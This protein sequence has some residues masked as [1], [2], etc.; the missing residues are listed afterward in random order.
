MSAVSAGVTGAKGSF[1]KQAYFTNTITTLL[2]AMVAN[3]K[4]VEAR[5]QQ[6]L[7]QPVADYPLPA[8]LSDLEAY[9]EAGTITG[10]LTGIAA[11]SGV[12]A[13]K[14]DEILSVIFGEDVA[15]VKLEKF[16]GWDGTNFTDAGNKS[17]LDSWMRLQ[18]LNP[19]IIV[20][21]LSSKEF[22]DRRAEAVKFFKL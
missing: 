19:N 10:A 2:G 4:T 12:K 15:T 16:I 13:N 22:A 3:R 18:G 20:L 7:S 5:I 14:A 6:R 21:F 8:A 11:D 1:D 17:K 9:Y